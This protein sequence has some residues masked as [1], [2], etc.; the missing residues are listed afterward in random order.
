MLLSI[1]LRKNLKK[2]QK[3]LPRIIIEKYL[4]HIQKK[5]DYLLRKSHKCRGNYFYLIIDIIF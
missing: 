4:V 3:P 2:L 5:V 1:P